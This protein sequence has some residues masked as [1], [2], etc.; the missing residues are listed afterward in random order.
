MF[1]RKNN[2]NNT[3]TSAA[4]A[5]VRYPEHGKPVYSLSFGIT[6]Y[7][8]LNLQQFNLVCQQ[9]KI[10]RDSIVWGTPNAQLERDY[11]AMK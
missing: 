2:T 9:N 11:Y 1:N 3:S 5:S 7:T 10:A 4:Y 8:D 6:R